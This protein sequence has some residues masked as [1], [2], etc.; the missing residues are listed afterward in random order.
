MDELR[1]LL[2]GEADPVPNG[3]HCATAERRMFVPFVVRRCPAMALAICREHGLLHAKVEGMSREDA[4][5]LY[6]TTLVTHAM[7]N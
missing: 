7:E 1:S 4:D 5:L 6:N 3:F 2:D